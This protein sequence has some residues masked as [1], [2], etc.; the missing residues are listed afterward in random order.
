VSVHIGGSVRA[1]TPAV[2]DDLAIFDE[3]PLRSVD[4][5]P[6][7]LRPPGRRGSIV[8]AIWALAIASLVGVGVLASEPVDGGPPRLADAAP[9]V[10]SAP[11]RPDSGLPSTRMGALLLRDA[12]ALE[13]P[14]PERVEITTH[15]LEVA[16]T[17]LVRAAR[18]EIALGVRGRRALDHVSIDV[19][20][21]NGGIRPA[22]T[23]TF[24][25][26]FE[27]PVP[28][29]SGTMWVVVAAY[30]ER[31]MPLGAIRRPFIVGPLPEPEVARADSNPMGERWRPPPRR[32]VELAA[33]PPACLPISPTLASSC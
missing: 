27:L 13:S 4:F 30:D 32:I 15:R 10:P 25:A 22:W 7:A 28:R 23:P 14:A 26:S 2:D 33:R 17:V 29:P 18:V 9:S 6:R 12:I 5:A 19:A 3:A 31:G 24:S 20:D 8:A 11:P 21:P 16:G 1:V